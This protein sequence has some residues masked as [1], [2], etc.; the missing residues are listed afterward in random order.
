MNFGNSFIQVYVCTCVIVSHFVR[1]SVLQDI[2]GD[3]R[4]LS[5]IKKA[6]L[7]QL[8][9][10]ML[11]Q[12]KLCQ[13]ALN[14][15]LEEKRSRF[16][17][18]YFLGDEDLLE[19]LGQ[20]T[21]PHVIQSHLKKLFAGI[22]TVSFNQ[23]ST[24]LTA[25]VSQDGEVV[26]LLHPVLVHKDIEVSLDLLTREMKETLKQLLIQCIAKSNRKDESIDPLKYPS[27]VSDHTHFKSSSG[28]APGPS[29]Q[30]V[31]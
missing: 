5:L 21:N 1:R 31:F 12:L 8:L 15:F 7:K 2:Q 27:Q 23:D 19:I 30:G 25:M 16:P 22:H 13:K 18:F 20:S 28:H 4:L 10:N 14:E 29:H 24:F 11:D 9:S 17:R 26:E 6:G 3:T